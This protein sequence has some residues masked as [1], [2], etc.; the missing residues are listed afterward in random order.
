MPNFNGKLET[1]ILDV[2]N[3]CHGNRIDK[4]ILDN[5]FVI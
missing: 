4:N 5:I 2:T 1:F 3:F